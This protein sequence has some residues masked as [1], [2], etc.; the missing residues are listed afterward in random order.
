MNPV[1]NVTAFYFSACCYY[2]GQAFIQRVRRQQ[3][4]VLLMLEHS[5]L[6]LTCDVSGA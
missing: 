3:K 1:S 2:N 6:Y 5:N 4:G